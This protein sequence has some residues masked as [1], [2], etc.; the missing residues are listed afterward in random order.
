MADWEKVLERGGHG[1]TAGKMQGLGIYRGLCT[2]SRFMRSAHGVA[3]VIT[4]PTT[5]LVLF[6]MVFFNL[7]R[8][9][10]SYWIFILYIISLT[11]AVTFIVRT[12]SPNEKRRSGTGR[13]S[14]ETWFSWS[15]FPPLLV[16]L[17]FL[18]QNPTYFLRSY[19]LNLFDFAGSYVVMGTNLLLIF[20]IHKRID[21]PPVSNSSVLD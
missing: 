4:I 16:S 8:G 18:V 21:G 13:K 2:L 12:V 20:L 15:L 19:Q 6:L 17:L 1:V 3:I 11:D 14:K 7:D 5:A 10:V 9:A